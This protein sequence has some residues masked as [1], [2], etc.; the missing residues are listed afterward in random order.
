MLL[1]PRPVA[2]ADIPSLPTGHRNQHIQACVRREIASKCGHLQTDVHYCHQCFNWVIG[3]EEW[4]EHCQT[5]IIDLGSKRCGTVTYCHTLVRP[6]YC[7]FCLGTSNPT[8]QR[9]KSWCRD[10]ALWQHVDK[11]LQGSKWPKMCPHPLCDVPL[12]DSQD[13]RF[14][15]IDDHGLS[16]TVPKDAKNLGTVQP[17][18]EEEQVPLVKR[19][20]SEESF[21]LF[22]QSPEQFSTTHPR[23]KTRRCS[24]TIAPSL[25]SS[26]DTSTLC[27][28]SPI[29]LTGHFSQNIFR[30]SDPAVI[31]KRGPQARGLSR[32]RPSVSSSIPVLRKHCR[33]R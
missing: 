12:K 30:R 14:H 26:I 21:E 29:D 20:A 15:F 7:P 18:P 13:L 17:Y 4:K 27:P 3:P 6:A 8:G 31:D 23:K 22:W 9:L 2:P 32:F 19:K 33:R 5:H 28:T 10:H 11:H 24:S 16:R 25:L 1:S